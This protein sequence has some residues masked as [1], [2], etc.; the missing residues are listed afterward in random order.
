M[1]EQTSKQ[2]PVLSVELIPGDPFH[3]RLGDLA[4]DLA[5]GGTIGVV[6]ALPSDTSASYQLRPPGGGKDWRANCDG[7]TLRPVPP[8]ITHV[9]PQKR[10]AIYNRRA[11]RGALPVTV[12][13]EDGGSYESTLILTPD[14][15]E[16][17]HIQFTQL[18]E[19]K[20]TLE[21]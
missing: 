9:T 13:Y 1:A 3:P 14:Q 4:L 16:L 20:S 19:A 15:V 18:I 21:Q 7:T 6:V 11:K 10:D 5:K 17:Y 8:R 12:H 2:P